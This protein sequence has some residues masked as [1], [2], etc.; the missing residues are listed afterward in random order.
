VPSQAGVIRSR[1][2]K[3]AAGTI[4]L[5]IKKTRD[6]MN[7]TVDEA[8]DSAVG[9]VARQ[10]E[11]GGSHERAA[12]LAALLLVG[13]RLARSLDRAIVV[14]R[15][16]ARDA[17]AKRLAAELGAI[18][19]ALSARELATYDHREDEA[20]AT[21][22]SQTLS[23]AWQATAVYTVLSALRRDTDVARGLR[24]TK[25]ALASR[26]ELTAATESAQAFNA[27]RREGLRFATER[28]E[29]LELAVAKLGRRWDA[30]LDACDD[31]SAHDGDVTGVNDDFGGDEPGEFHVNCRCS[32]TLVTMDEE[33]A[34]A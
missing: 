26:I 6:D 25:A 2:A 28:D 19:I 21:L 3:L 32:W 23:A 11:E 22:A 16:S 17:G 27:E 24:R 10:R 18:G 13:A 34:S 29:A 31:C 12:A 30:M 4:L 15:R 33:R 8:I 20:R 9:A 5:A 14:A 1:A 7:E